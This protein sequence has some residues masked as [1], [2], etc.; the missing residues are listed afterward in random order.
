[1]IGGFVPLFLE[2]LQSTTVPATAVV[3]AA[4]G[5]FGMV[6]PVILIQ[7]AK[8]RKDSDAGV[9]AAAEGGPDRTRSKSGV[10]SED[11]ADTEAGSNADRDNGGEIN[12]DTRGDAD[13]PSPDPEESDTERQVDFAELLDA[14]DS[15]ASELGSGA[16][17]D[18]EDAREFDDLTDPAA[19]H[20]DLLAP[21]AIEWETRVARV[22][23]Q[24]TSTL[25]VAG[26]PDYP[27]DGYLS[28]LF[29]LTDVEFDLT[30]DLTPKN[31]R[32]AKDEL[33]DTADDL[34][35]EADLERTVRGAYLQERA[36]EATAT[37]KAVE[38]GQRVFSQAT[39]ITVR[40]DTRDELRESVKKIRATLREQPA[41]LEPKTAI[42]TQDLAIQSG[43]PVGPN[44]LG[45]EAIALGGAVGALLASPHNPT[46]LEE[47]GVEFGTHRDTHSPVVVDPFG[48]DDGYAMFTVGDP[49]SGK[50]FSA[51]QNF[52]RTLEQDEDRIGVI[53]EPLNDWVGVAEALDAKRITVGGTMGLNPLEIKPTPERVLR[54]RGDDASPL[55]ERR[56]RAVSFLTNFFALRNVDLGDRR[57]TLE[58]ALDEAYERKGITEDVSTHDR[59]S[60]TITDILDILD[61][62]G[63]DPGP[64]VVRSVAE[65][66]KL[67]AD[68][69]WL[70]DQL[71]PFDSGGR[72][73][74]L[75]RE[76]E[77]DI[78]DED[79]VY[80]DLA[81][82][83]GSLGGHTSLLME[84][85]VSLV[86]ERA[87]ETEKE[88]VFIIDE[89]RYLMKDA[90]TLSYLETIFR[91]HRHHDLSIQLITQTVDEFFQR[92]VAEII[93]D[94]CAVKQ[95]HK[96][97]GMDK[98]WANEFGLNHAQMRFV[99]NAMP[100]D[101]EQGYSQALLGVDGEWRGIEVSA[102][103]RE[104]Q[105]ID[106][107]P[108]TTVLSRDVSSEN[109]ARRRPFTL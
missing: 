104:T 43:A 36:V 69:V 25:Y 91:H 10:V 103:D 62:M 13:E 17:A 45:R 44:P 47:G 40:A 56:D 2:W 32:R 46:I 50:S 68:A 28:G 19:F 87:K 99:Q 106:F 105:V 108:E 24:W 101:E 39:F 67:A 77:F 4:L 66:E 63:E 65:G 8:S 29:E 102:L 88:V 41:G 72:F 76:S 31:Q 109:D 51:K 18:S 42:C 11:S 84:L 54:A 100:G 90:E 35:A 95:F 33:Q 96:L 49:G 79:V 15:A 71:R 59:D 21:A 9:S 82:R 23:E 75:G 92:D 74:N 64:Y 27:K 53:L 3:V 83:G 52:L 97:D 85:L 16:A 89:A 22:G 98:T 86:Y 78:R 12:Q 1:M 5:V 73:E 55:K 61:E 26:Y 60:P 80:L 81:Q 107:D 20:R 57:T 48:R 14:D 93:L 37:Y 70:L 30:I 58:M 38:N 6:G 94:Q 7:V 34:Q